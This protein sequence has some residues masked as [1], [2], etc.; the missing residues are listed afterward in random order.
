MHKEA[1]LTKQQ[2]EEVRAKNMRERD[3]FESK[4][5]G[6]FRKSF[7]ND[8]PVKTSIL[9]VF[10]RYNKNMKQSLTL[11][12]TF[13]TTKTAPDQPTCRRSPFFKELGVEF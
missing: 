9:N 5:L 3:A 7:P 10:S 4:N 13:G 6:G 1:P 12:S 11:Q 8:D 2:K